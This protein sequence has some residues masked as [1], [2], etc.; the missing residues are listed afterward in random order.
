MSKT[1]ENL[2]QANVDHHN[3]HPA[4]HAAITTVLAVGGLVAI[5]K[6]RQ[7]IINNDRKP[8]SGQYAK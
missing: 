2:A 8:R 1:F 3:N 5:G 4:A 7:R 6:I